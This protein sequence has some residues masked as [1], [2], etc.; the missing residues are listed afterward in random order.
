MAFNI[1]DSIVSVLSKN[2]PPYI[3]SFVTDS[4]NGSPILI[5]FLNF[6][7]CVTG[8]DF[9][10]FRSRKRVSFAWPSVRQRLVHFWL[11]PWVSLPFLS[12]FVCIIRLWCVGVLRIPLVAWV[13]LATVRFFGLLGLLVCSL[14]LGCIILLELLKLFPQGCKGP[15]HIGHRIAR[16]LSS[17]CNC[18]F[19]FLSLPLWFVDGLE[20]G[21]IGIFLWLFV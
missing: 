11:I 18:I 16:C 17:I 15:L 19:S 1:F 10:G 7:P 13:I 2:Y 9:L 20:R 3:K 6:I 4:G 12:T 5:G 14:A 8:V 21:Q